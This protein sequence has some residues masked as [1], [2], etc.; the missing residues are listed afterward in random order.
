MKS[1]FEDE[2][3]EAILLVDASN[4]FNTL[5]RQAALRNVQKFCPVLAPI[6]VNTHCNHA[7]LFI[8]GEHIL[9]REGTAQGDPLAMAMYGIGTLP[10]ILQ[11]RENVT[12]CWYA[13]D[14]TAGGKRLHI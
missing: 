13:D 14:A 7:K 4:A 12:Q 5:N 10:L 6:L 8:G 3:T 9:C 2:G 1:V 11:L